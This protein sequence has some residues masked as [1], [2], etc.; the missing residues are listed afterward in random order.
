MQDMQEQFEE[1]GYY[2]LRGVLTEQEVDRLSKPIRGGFA[3]REYD[4]HRG[5]GVYPQPGI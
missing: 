2:V 5:E 3:A 1:N 4:S